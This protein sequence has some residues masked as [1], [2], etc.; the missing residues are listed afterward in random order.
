[1]VPTLAL[2]S[3]DD[4]PNI[5]QAPLPMEVLIKSIVSVLITGV[6]LLAGLVVAYAILEAAYKIV[7]LM[8]LG[9]CT[10]MDIHEDIRLGLGKWLALALEFSLAADILASVAAP[11]FTEI[12]KL[13]AIAAIR[14]GLNYFLNKEIQELKSQRGATPALPTVGDPR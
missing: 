7:V 13:A 2:S 4:D 8:I 11:T 1:M 12:G 3:P 14:T 9:Q 10:P 5:P 6:E